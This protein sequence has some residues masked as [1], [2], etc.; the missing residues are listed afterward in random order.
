MKY[1]YSTDRWGIDPNKTV[2]YELQFKKDLLT[3]GSKFKVKYDR[4]TYIFNCLVHLKKIVDGVETVVTWI[5][6]MNANGYKSIRPENIV[7]VVK[8]KR[9][10]RKNVN[11]A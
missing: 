5:E 2:V 8:P 11:R 6:C 1:P 3:P 4:S 9:S 7:K 10:Y